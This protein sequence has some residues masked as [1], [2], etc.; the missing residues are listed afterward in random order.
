MRTELLS[1]IVA[2]SVAGMM[3]RAASE[4]RRGVGCRILALS[5]EE[6]EAEYWQA[7]GH[8]ESAMRAARTVH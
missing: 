2:K 1:P 7:I 6:R 8:A 3:L 4:M 5:P